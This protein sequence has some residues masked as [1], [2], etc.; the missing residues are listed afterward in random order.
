[1]IKAP[2]PGCEHVKIKMIQGLVFSPIFKNSSTPS[3][4]DFLVQTYEIYS[5]DFAAEKVV[6]YCK[7]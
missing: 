4:M 7:I 5:L 2:F 3:F 1:M 6:K